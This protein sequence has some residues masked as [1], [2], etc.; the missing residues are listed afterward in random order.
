MGWTPRP[1]WVLVSSPARQ[2]PA[3][4]RRTS[5]FAASMPKDGD[6]SRRLPCRGSCRVRA[7]VEHRWRWASKVLGSTFP[8][9]APLPATRL[10][11]RFGWSR[12]GAS[13][14][15]LT[16][17]S[18]A[19]FS[20]GHLKAWDSMRVI[21]P[22]PCR[23]FSRER[24]GMVLAEGAGALV[25]EQL[26]SARARGAHIHAEVK[27]FGLSSDAAHITK[28]S[29]SGAARALEGALADA[30]FASDSIDYVNAHGTGT[31]LNDVTE[32]RALK[33][34]LGDR[35]HQVAISSS[36]SM[37]GHGLGAAGALECVATVLALENGVIPPT[38]NYLGPDP[39]CD[40][41][42]VPNSSREQPIRRALSNSF[43]FGGL[44]AVLALE[45]WNGD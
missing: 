40:L 3:R 13:A 45:R 44:N 1:S 30:A 41:D 19:P 25:L 42:V 37:H 20:L 31:V 4:R 16:G 18:E 5:C 10:G 29:A 7:R 33:T 34:V 8:P 24:K 17:G 2:W 28:P 22:E 12:A 23:P 38:A 36:K 14:A 21:S 39:D 15:A 26:D 6:G 43:A 11:S 9:R 27:G 32:T 35:V